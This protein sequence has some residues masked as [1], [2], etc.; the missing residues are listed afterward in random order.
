MVFFY[1]S[2][3]FDRIIHVKLNGIL[4]SLGFSG[5]ALKCVYFYLTGRSQS[6]LDHENNPS[7]STP[8]SCGIPQGSVLGPLL[9]SLYISS[10]RDVLSFCDY[11]IYA[12]DIQI[13]LFCHSKDIASCVVK[14]NEDIKSIT[15]WAEGL[16]LLL[17]EAKTKAIIVGTSRYI[18][19]I[20]SAEIPRVRVRDS[21]LPQYGVLGQIPSW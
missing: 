1:F 11:S 6:V 12:D 7:S 9:F 10:F 16:C 18:D 3:A 20:N 19:S 17:N 15:I 2:K 8:V 13:F 14:V 4:E 5:S 21:E